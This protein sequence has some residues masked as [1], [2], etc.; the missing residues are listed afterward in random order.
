MYDKN[1]S[2]VRHISEEIHPVNERVFVPTKNNVRSPSARY[3]LTSENL[4]M[5]GYEIAHLND[6]HAEV[7]NTF[8][9][10]RF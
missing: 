9:R 1:K 2:I 4:K 10:K 8:E 7:R 3:P 6:T 5:L